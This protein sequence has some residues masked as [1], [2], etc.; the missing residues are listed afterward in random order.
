MG[1]TSPQRYVT[2]IPSY[3]YP[4]VRAAH[5][6]A[7]LSESNRQES[8]PLFQAGARITRRADCLADDVHDMVNTVE[9]ESEYALQTD[10]NQEALNAIAGFP[11]G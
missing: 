4:P 9:A 11:D 1:I 7:T 2:V 10:S 5:L 3:A 8:F 6:D